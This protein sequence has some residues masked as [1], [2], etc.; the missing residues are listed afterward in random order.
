MVGPW[1][2]DSLLH[3][4]AEAIVFSGTWMGRDAVLKRRQPRNWRHPDL[5]ARLTKSRL[6]A[7]TRLL[8]RLHQNGLPVPELL[9]I[10]ATEGW[11]IISKCPGIPL[12]EALR[13]GIQKEILRDVGMLIRRIHA[14]GMTHGDLTTHNILWDEESGL[15]IIDFGLS[16]IT[17]DLEPLGLDLQVLNEC[18]KASHPSIECGIDLVVE[19][20][21]E[22]EEDMAKAVILRFD[23]IRSRVRYHG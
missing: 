21:L 13:V 7:E 16:S 3:R 22:T 19:G 6:S 2:E 9:A 10:D 20:Y 4:G 5:D 8:R 15:S 1:I 11:I 23:G 14:A 12:F 18:L 17:Y